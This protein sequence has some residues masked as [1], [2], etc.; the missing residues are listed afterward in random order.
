MNDKL[1][2][3]SPWVL[4]FHEI[5]AFFK[6]DD[7]VRVVLDKE[8]NNYIIKLYVEDEE[9]ADA[10]AQLLPSEK[11]IGNIKVTIAVIPPNKLGASKLSL[12]QK[13]FKG[14]P[15]VAYTKSVDG[16]YNNTLN[17]IVFKNKVV[18]YYTDDLGD[19]NHVRSTLYQDIAKELFGE[20]EGIFYCTDKPES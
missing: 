5:E 20:H 14:N 4:L 7:E 1:T 13:A 8:E 19:I 6:E 16:L 15:A 18:Q 12:F 10:L 2:L 9:K 3:S 17:F 11:Q